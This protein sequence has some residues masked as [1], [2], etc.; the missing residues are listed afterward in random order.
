VDDRLVLVR[1]KDA[2]RKNRAGKDTRELS[3]AQL[4]VD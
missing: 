3:S 1:G 4:Y 2:K